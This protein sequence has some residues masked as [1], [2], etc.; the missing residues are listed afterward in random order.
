MAFNYDSERERLKR[1]IIGVVCGGVCQAGRILNPA[2][3]P[4]Y[5]EC[6]CHS[7]FIRQA[8]YLSAGIPLKYWDFTLEELTQ[9]FVDNNPEA[10]ELVYMYIDK[11]EE[12]VKE[13]KGFFLYGGRGLGKTGLGCIILK[14]ALDHGVRA[15]FVNMPV[16]TNR[17]YD[18]IG[19]D[20]AK[21]E[22]VEDRHQ[23]RDETD[24]LVVDQIDHVFKGEEGAG[25]VSNQIDAFYNEVVYN[26]RKAVIL[27]ANLAQQQLQ[28]A[29][30]LNVVDRISELASFELK[31][32]SFRRSESNEKKKSKLMGKPFKGLKDLAPG[33]KTRTVGR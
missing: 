28:A 27:T 24:L 7:L 20:A 2:K 8:R 13:A 6:R 22:L 1:S 3:N 26:T 25:W 11:I 19:N 9:E 21:A 12:C 31:G 4:P 23:L 17:L 32:Q 10:M 16:W 14:A 33:G 15:A 30:P 29:L 5:E 18:A